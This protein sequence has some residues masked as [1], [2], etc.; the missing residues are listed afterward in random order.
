MHI[1]RDYFWLIDT[2]KFELAMRSWM[3]VPDPHWEARN[4]TD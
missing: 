2:Y 4:I 1:F 3:E